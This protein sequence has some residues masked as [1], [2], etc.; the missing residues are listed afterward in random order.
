MKTSPLESIFLQLRQGSK[1]AVQNGQQLSELDTYLHVERPIDL[2]VQNAMI[3]IQKEG[4][5]IILLTGSAGDGKSHMISKIKKKFPD[6]LFHNDASESP[7]HK[8]GAIEALKLHISDMADEHL[9]TTTKKIVVAINIG[10]LSTFVDDEEAQKKFS[11]IVKISKQ[12][13]NKD[14]EHLTESNRIK[15]IT[16]ANQQIFELYPERTKETYPVDSIFIRN[17]LEKI[18]K[19][20]IDNYFYRAYLNS[21]PPDSEYDPVYIN[22]QLLMEHSTQDSIVKIIIESI[23][24][25]KLT[26]TPRELL[27][28]ISRIVVP[29]RTGAFEPKSDFFWTLL[30]N[31]LF[32]GGDNKI[33]KSVVKLDPIKFGCTS[34]ND[35]MSDLY[36]S[37]AIHKWPCLTFLKDSLHNIF[38]KLLNEFIN[39]NRKNI[40]DISILL[41]RLEHLLEYHS[42]SEVY[43]DF[44]AQLC[45]YYNEDDRL[46]HTFELIQMNI[47]RYYGAYVD[48]DSINLVPLSI[49]GQ[50]FKIF[51]VCHSLKEDI[52]QD[53][54][55]FDYK[56]RSQFEIEIKTL[57]KINPFAESIPFNVEYS[58][59]EYLSAV[60]KGKLQLR[61]DREKCISLGKFIESIVRASDYQETLIILTPDNKKLTLKKTRSNKISLK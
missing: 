51:S 1:L 15:V 32:S 27:D 19:K 13:L 2:A 3:D 46:Q 61:Q 16:F 53:S 18:T 47:P 12:L 36:T 20:D 26:V 11:S 54:V 10:K 8:L 39:N 28:F 35:K 14:Y 49:Q 59:F 5:G 33:L 50:K 45:G 21:T 29:E 9:Y 55:C 6:F 58:I 42:E 34:H 60:A 57:W 37:T 52:N 40:E 24:R 25:H 41:L 31:R 38:F 17:I 56:N 4:G 23:V 30:P 48:S 22:Y 44:L 43:R 7:S